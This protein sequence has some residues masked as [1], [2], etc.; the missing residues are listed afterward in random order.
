MLY[1]LAVLFYPNHRIHLH[2]LP[3][4]QDKKIQPSRKHQHFVPDFQRWQ[5]FKGD[6][7]L[8]VQVNAENRD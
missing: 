4:L 7:V 6:R 8:G 3:N 1:S 5:Y 2:H